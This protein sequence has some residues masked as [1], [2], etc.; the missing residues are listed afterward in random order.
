MLKRLCA[1]LFVLAAGAFA[2]LHA[3]DAWQAG[4]HYSVIEPAQPG[5]TPGKVEVTEVFS[6][7]CPHCSD[8]QP[9]VEQIRSRLPANATFVLMPATLGFESWT[10][11]ARAYY[12][13]QALGIADKAHAALF[14]AVF[15]EKKISSV[16]PTIESLAQ[17]YSAYGVSAE[18]FIAT[19][20]SFAIG[21]RIKRAEALLKAYGIDGTPAF[22]VAGKYRVSAQ[23]AGGWTE[24][25]S[26]INYLVAKESG[27]S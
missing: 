21:T 12:T 6:Y 10:T 15:K 3:E 27:G 2:P 1:V 4:K 25:S 26:L 18:D 11:F 19:S 24:L 22:V 8:A 9:M 20:K 13:A 5:S 7:A 23:S 14:D 16:K 17:F